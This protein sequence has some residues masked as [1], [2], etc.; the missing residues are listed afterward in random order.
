[1]YYVTFGTSDSQLFRGGWVRIKA[2]TMSEA[3]DKFVS[4]YK[5]DARDKNG[6][7]RYCTIYSEEQFMSTVMGQE[8]WNLGHAEHEYI[9]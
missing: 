1:V 4:R 3:I 5:A 2:D 6:F 9:E 8:M 7:L